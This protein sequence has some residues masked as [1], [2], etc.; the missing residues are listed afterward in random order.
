MTYRDLY[1]KIRD[2]LKKASESPGSEA[3]L[4]LSHV[5][6]QSKEKL[7]AKF[8]EKVDEEI[9]EKALNLT[10]IRLMGIPLQYITRRCYFYGLELDIIPGVFIP[11]METEVL[12]EVALEVIKKK[13]IKSVVDIGTGSGAI[14]IAISK[15]SNCECFATDVSS[16]AL[17][18]ASQNALK[19]SCKINFLFGPFL[20][21]LKNLLDKIQLIV[22]N[23]PYVETKA[24]LQR[25]VL[26][27]PPEALFAGEDGMDFYKAFF[28]QPK[29]L[30]GKTIIMEFSPEQKLKLEKLLSHLGRLTFFQDQFMKDRFFML[31]M[32]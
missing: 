8:E 16:L 11:R 31:E 27:E 22:S 18:I 12:V 10:T 9:V 23:P 32:L 1:L 26:Q 24:K 2:I 3:L 15:N 5:I 19:H 4:L 13:Q 21:P 28:S 17:Q 6:N 7:L 30:K 20:E 25:E 29:L 14:I